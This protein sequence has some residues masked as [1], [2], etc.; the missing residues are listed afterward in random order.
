[1][2]PVEQMIRRHS[3]RLA[4][5]FAEREDLDQEGRILAWQLR[6]MPDHYI[7]GAVWLKMLQVRRNLKR[8]VAVRVYNGDDED[9]DDGACDRDGIVFR[10]GFYSRFDDALIEYLSMPAKGKPGPKTGDKLTRMEISVLREMCTGIEAVDL[11]DRICVGHRTI[12][13][14]LRNVYTKLGVHNLIQA[15]NAAMLAGIVEPPR[16]R[17]EIE[18]E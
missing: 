5:H 11:A 7:R 10:R 9:D 16:R 2:D 4:T 14:H 1:M 8:R 12:H 6:H 3:R 15:Y 17:D 18:T 13:Y